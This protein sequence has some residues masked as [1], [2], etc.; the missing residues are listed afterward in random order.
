MYIKRNAAN[1]TVATVAEHC[2]I[3]QIVGSKDRSVQHICP[4]SE[5]LPAGLS[6]S[7]TAS[8][9]LLLKQLSHSPLAAVFTCKQAVPEQYSLKPALLV[10]DDPLGAL[11]KAVE[12]FYENIRPEAGI[13]PLADIHPEAKIGE[14]VTV[15]AFCHIGEGASIADNCV[16][17][18]HVT[19]YPFAEIGRGSVLHSGVS[20][21]EFVKIGPN[22]VIQNG[23]II[24]ADGFGYIPDPDCG[25]KHVPQLGSVVLD[26]GVEIGANTCID[27]GTFGD[28]KLG[29][30]VK[31]DNLVQAGHNVRIGD[32]SI[33]CG[34]TG[35]AGSTTIGDKVTIGG[36]AGTKDGVKI[37]SNV[38]IAGKSGVVD[39]IS[40]AGDYGGFPAVKAHLWRRQIAALSALPRY[41]SKIRKL[42]KKE[43]LS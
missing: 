33:I 19:V 17:F 14:N 23:A 7:R 36:H 9:E 42:L 43:N 4:L 30:A 5:P 40:E 21:R 28:T 12:L 34:M 25:I 2:E 22:S 10:C 11:T 29:K 3:T 20:V 38:R 39:D 8:P 37:T 6:F 16:L 1:L 41:L 27:R 24:G 31:I 32:Y 15:S 26:Q 13:S 18:P 35:L